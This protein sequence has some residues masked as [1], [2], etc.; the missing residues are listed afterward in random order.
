ME[1]YDG[2]TPVVR[3]DHLAA[4]EVEFLRWKAERGMKLRHF[5]VVFRH[6]PWFVM[7]NGARMLAHT[8]RGCNFR[9]FMGWEDE[10]LAFRRYQRIRKQERAYL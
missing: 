3:T 9:T 4:D 8:F 1:E 7:R 5:P 6:S 10:R 2:T